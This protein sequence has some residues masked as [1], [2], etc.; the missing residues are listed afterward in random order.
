MPDQ[1]KRT[2]AL[3][4][5]LIFAPSRLIASGKELWK[6][7]VARMGYKGGAERTIVRW[8]GNYL[9]I[10]SAR[11]TTDPEKGQCVLS[12]DPKQP[13]L[14]FDAIARKQVTADVLGS[15]GREWE[16]PHWRWP[17]DPCAPDKRPKQEDLPEPLT[18]DLDY[19][20]QDLKNFI[21]LDK[22]HKERFRIS[23]GLF[24]CW[25]G[26][27]TSSRS[28]DRFA[29][30]DKGRTLGKWITDNTVDLISDFV[31]TNKKRI[32][33]YDAKHGKKL[34]QVSWVEPKCFDCFSNKGERVAFS[35]DGS[36]L[37]I[38]D[39]EGVLR[40]VRISEE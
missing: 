15:L 35:D 19:L 4:L 26:C 30:L 27:V 10:G 40:V 14:V 5:L 7:N 13:V 17:P 33:V 38:L 3:A 21:V 23:P 16:P 37:A 18:S 34:Y 12:F 39:D 32:R 11:F 20:S 6:V 28:G 22:N 31:D 9:V 25:S 1:R 36:M 2:I 24:S 29:L 8:H